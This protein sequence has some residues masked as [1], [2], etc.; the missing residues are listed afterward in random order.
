VPFLR[1]R[2]TAGVWISVLVELETFI[3]I[4]MIILSFVAEMKPKIVVM[5][6]ETVVV[7]FLQNERRQIKS[8]VCIDLRP[9]CS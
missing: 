9:V 3:L 6:Q 5:K 7:Y 4:F 2:L 8:L 1:I